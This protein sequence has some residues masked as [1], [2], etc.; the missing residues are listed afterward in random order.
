MTKNNTNPNALEY[1]HDY[2][3]R[4]LLHEPCVMRYKVVKMVREDPRKS[5]FKDDPE[6]EKV[7]I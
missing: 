2:W 6:H 3:A 7:R 4:D 1:D 5:A